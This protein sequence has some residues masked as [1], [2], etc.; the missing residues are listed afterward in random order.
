MMK[1]EC[2]SITHAT[3]TVFISIEV[4]NKIKLLFTLIRLLFVIL[5]DQF[6][7]IKH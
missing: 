7:L 1:R 4:K 6:F 3:Y 5:T 2:L